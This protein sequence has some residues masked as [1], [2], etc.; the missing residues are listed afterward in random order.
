MILGYQPLRQA[1]QVYYP[2]QKAYSSIAQEK[3]LD[4]PILRRVIECFFVPIYSS[5]R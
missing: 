1:E 3:I 2:L 4:S 5:V